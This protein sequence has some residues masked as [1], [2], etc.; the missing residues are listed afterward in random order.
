LADEITGNQGD[1]VYLYSSSNCAVSGNNIANNYEGIYL[2]ASSESTISG[3]NITAN[4]QFGVSLSTDSSNC[5][6]SRN[7]FTN[8]GLFVFGALHS[9]VVDNLVNGKPLVYLEDISDY[10]VSDAG[11]V[12]LVNCDGIVVNNLNLRNA[13]IGVE[14]WQT[15][16][17]RIT[18]DNLTNNYDGV[19]L[20]S[21]FENTISGSNIT[22]NIWCGVSLN[23]SSTNWFFHDNFVN[24]TLQVSSDGSPNT[25]DNGYPSGGNYWSDYT[26]VDQKSGS[27]QNLTGSDGIGDT[28]YTIDSS[29][30]DHYPLM[31]P[32]H[33][34]NAGTWNNE[35]YSVSIDSN[36]TL[37]NFSFNATAKTLSFNVT[38]TSGTLGFCRVAIPNILMSCAD[39]NDWIV[40]VNGTLVGDRTIT[41]SGNYTYVYFRYYHSTETVQITSTISIP[42]FQPLMLMPLLM[43]IALLAA[44]VSKK[45]LK[46]SHITNSERDSELL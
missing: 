8:D 32:F 7:A 29:N 34:F 2:L 30:V 36:S 31:A 16:N 44:M 27:G 10:E 18:N 43:I 28:P 42:E 22:T 15:N 46:I 41:T 1:G 13:S 45:K 25:W 9:V 19:Y 14:L 35:S 26:G 24:N 12:V 39:P 6:V 5:T 23:L 11:Q 33:T 21:S 20:L 38:G 40:K 17:T 37:S 3:N 4:T